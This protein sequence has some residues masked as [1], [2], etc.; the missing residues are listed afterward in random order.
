MRFA[1]KEAQ[2]NARMDEISK[3]VGPVDAL[4]NIGVENGSGSSSPAE[5]YK[6]AREIETVSGY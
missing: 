3:D 2:D 4:R 1:D 5:K 6:A